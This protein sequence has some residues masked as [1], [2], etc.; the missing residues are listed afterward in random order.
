MIVYQ[1]KRRP[2]RIA[3]DEYVFHA[4]MKKGKLVSKPNEVA[5]VQVLDC[6][7]DLDDMNQLVFKMS[8]VEASFLEQTWPQFDLDG[9]LGV[10][11]INGTNGF[12]S[13]KQRMHLTDFEEVKAFLMD[14]KS[15]ELV[16]LRY[17]A[18]FI[19]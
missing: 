8:I 14:S 13:L 16:R 11:N 1:T 6:A 15:Y 2:L 19:T 10:W 3:F 17:E 12:I 9:I 4:V 5:Y 7:Q 18:N